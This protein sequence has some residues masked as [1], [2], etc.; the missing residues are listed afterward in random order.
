MKIINDITPDLI[1]KK[2]RC[3]AIKPEASKEWNDTVGEI[4]ELDRLTNSVT[5]KIIS[6]NFF[7]DKYIG[8]QTNFPLMGGWGFTIVDTDWDE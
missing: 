1:G 3:I 8:T 6:T 5:I 7:R 4:V 2:I